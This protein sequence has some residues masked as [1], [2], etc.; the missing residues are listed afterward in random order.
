MGVTFVGY[1][2]I[3]R[4][5]RKPQGSHKETSR[6]C[7]V[8]PKKGCA[9]HIVFATTGQLQEVEAQFWYVSYRGIRGRGCTHR[10]SI[11]VPIAKSQG[12]LG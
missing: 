4:L 8:Q 5:K 7:K 12:F 9:T 11:T 1:S 6:F 2:M 3:R 10:K